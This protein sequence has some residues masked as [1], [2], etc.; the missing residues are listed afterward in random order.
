LRQLV[1]KGLAFNVFV[2]NEVRVV[3]LD[4]VIHRSDAGVVQ[5]R[6]GTSFGCEAAA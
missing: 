3:L 6:C 2:H 1:P 4:K 5:S